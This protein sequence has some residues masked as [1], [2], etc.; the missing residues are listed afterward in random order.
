MFIVREKDGAHTIMVEQALDLQERS[1]GEE[2]V[3][4]NIARLTNLIERY[5]RRYPH[6]WGWMHR[7]WKSRPSETVVSGKS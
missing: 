7:R 2:A 1:D 4:I 5:I 6:E 3:T